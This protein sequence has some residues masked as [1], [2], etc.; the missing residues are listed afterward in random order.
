[1]PKAPKTSAGHKFLT[2]TLNAQ[3][4]GE[5]NRLPKRVQMAVN[6]VEVDRQGRT[7]TLYQKNFSDTT[8]AFHLASMSKQFFG[9]AVLQLLNDSSNDLN[10]DD[11]V[12]Q[13]ITDWPRYAAAVRVRHLLNH[14]SGL[15]EY[16]RNPVTYLKNTN[17]PASVLRFVKNQRSLL[18]RPGTFSLYC[19]TNYVLLANLIK[20]VSGQSVDRYMKQRIFDPLGMNATFVRAKKSPLPKVITNYYPVGMNQFRA[21]VRTKN[22]F[23]PGDG[24]VYTTLFDLKKWA[25]FLS[26]HSTLGADFANTMREDLHLDN[27]QASGYGY[28]FK[29]NDRYIRHSGSWN[30]AVSNCRFYPARGNRPG[31]WLVVLGNSN[32]I[33][34][35]EML[36]KM[37][38]A[39]NNMRQIDA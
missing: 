15:K 39:Y 7:S 32:G 13:H 33:D 19:N 24:G 4:L 28:G 17:D 25:L 3:Y 34:T 31:L 36:D 14:T 16:T 5:T 23:M 38:I 37:K 18:Q 9:L 27:G 22:D 12:N 1:M 6:I 26:G 29:I 10:L 2:S 21:A 20:E 8:R 30:G 35:F 11:R